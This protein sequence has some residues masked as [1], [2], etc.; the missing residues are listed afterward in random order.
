MET[1][2]GATVP[3]GEAQVFV[4]SSRLRRCAVRALGLAFAM[5]PVLWIVS[6]FLG[7]TGFASLPL[8]TRLVAA[9]PPAHVTAASNRQASLDV[10][11]DKRDRRGSTV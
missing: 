2:R 9:R 11:A 5:P 7:M 6:I 4:G 10:R 8:H 1:I 3:R